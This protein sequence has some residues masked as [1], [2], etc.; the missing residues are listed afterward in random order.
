MIVE[1]LA[2]VAMPVAGTL[3]RRGKGKGTWPNAAILAA[4]PALCTPLAFTLG[5]VPA[6]AAVIASYAQFV[7]S[8]HGLIDTG[9]TDGHALSDFALMMLRYTTGPVVLSIAG[10]SGWFPDCR[11]AI[12]AV[13][14]LTAL[15]YLLAWVARDRGALR[16]T[17]PTA[18]EE[19]VSGAVWF[20]A[21]AL[22]GGLM[23]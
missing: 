21:L 18:I 20:G 6:A 2:L 15:G 13:G 23:S 11:P 9:R 19:Y 1:T 3:W 8:H 16:E 4:M 7:P 14:I 22:A 17:E 5:P 12:G 10:L